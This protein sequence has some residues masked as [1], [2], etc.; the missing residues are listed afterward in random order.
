MNT[1]VLK[2]IAL[3]FLITIGCSKPK[4]I[5][6]PV[7][8]TYQ[9]HFKIIDHASNNLLATVAEDELNGA[10]KVHSKNG[11]I[12]GNKTFVKSYN[13][14][15][16]LTI[17]VSSQRDTFLE[18]I[19]YTIDKTSLTGST[20][21]ISF[22]VTWHEVKNSASVKNVYLDTQEIQATQHAGTTSFVYYLF[23]RP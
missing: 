14:E 1:T 20:S 21:P 19:D 11:T 6:A 23:T 8:Y 13:E 3:L 15:K 17:L 18:S 5:P 2:T 4:Q 9:I 16:L 22:N 7:P 10:V 12:I